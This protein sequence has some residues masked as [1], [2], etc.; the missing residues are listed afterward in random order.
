MKRLHTL[1]TIVGAGVLLAA[2]SA[3]GSGASPAEP[4]PA[5]PP[6]TATQAPDAEPDRQPAR[7]PPEGGV[8]VATAQVDTTGL[9]ENY[10]VMVWTLDN[11]STLG[12]VAQEGGCGKASAEITEQSESKV[13]ITLVETTPAEA[14]M[15]TMDLRYPKLTV[16]LAQPLG[17]RPVVLKNEQRKG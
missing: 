1:K 15:C 5:P 2:L 11:G 3:C 9:Q 4:A 7:T 12:V 17:E 8:Q 6:A 13:A 16:E 14:Q 10:P